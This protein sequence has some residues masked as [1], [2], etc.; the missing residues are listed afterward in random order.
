MSYI[1]DA[2]EAHLDQQ[3]AER[4]SERGEQITI[5]YSVGV[6]S[7]VVALSA[8]LHVEQADLVAAMLKAQAVS[9]SHLDDDPAYQRVLAEAKR[10][11]QFPDCC[12][13]AHA[14]AT[15]PWTCDCACHKKPVHPVK[16]PVCSWC[17]AS[18]G[19]AHV[20]GCPILALEEDR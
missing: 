19:Q 11:S 1:L 7:A 20:F 9:G 8:V 14:N 18:Q 13:A 4:G 6:L 10:R 17:H 16:A 2:L 5:S 3:K 12:M 15:A